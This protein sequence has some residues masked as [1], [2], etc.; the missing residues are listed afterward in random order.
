MGDLMSTPEYFFDTDLAVHSWREVA[1]CNNRTDV[2]FFPMPDDLV[3]I[4]AAK[5]V[6]TACPVAD[7]CLQ[8]AIETNQPDGIWGGMTSKERA[9]IRREWLKELRRAS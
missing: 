8:F 9:R 6:C 1:A 4:N 5:A 2:S 3:A 7:E